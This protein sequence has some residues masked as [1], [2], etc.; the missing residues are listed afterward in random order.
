[1]NRRQF[2][3]SAACTSALSA[4]PMATL[5]QSTSALAAPHIQ[6]VWEKPEFEVRGLE[7]HSRRM[8]DWK[9]VSTAFSLMEKLNLNMLIFHQDNLQDAVVWPDKYF[10]MDVRTYQRTIQGVHERAV[11]L[12]TARDYLRNVPAREIPHHERLASSAR[13]RQL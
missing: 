1:M 5:A 6:K 10:P 7:I 2:L 9:S 11:F 4:L 8:W 12:P 3:E 13:N